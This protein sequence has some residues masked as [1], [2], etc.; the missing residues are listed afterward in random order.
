MA[1]IKLN[2]TAIALLM[3]ARKLRDDGYDEAYTSAKKFIF[4]IAKAENGIDRDVRVKA[5]IDDT[6]H[7]DFGILKDADTGEAITID[8]KR[9]LLSDL[10]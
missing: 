2:S 6:N 10:V 5:E 3:Q 7:P 4:G 1:K 8:S 9:N